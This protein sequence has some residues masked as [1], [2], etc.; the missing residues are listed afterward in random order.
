MSTT[1]SGY[2]SYILPGLRQRAQDSLLVDEIHQ[3][4]ADRLDL[5]V[6]LL[7]GKLLPR[8]RTF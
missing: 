7:R 3:R 4:K 1:T 5:T 6:D 2:T 8:A